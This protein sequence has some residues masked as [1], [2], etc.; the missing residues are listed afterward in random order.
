[1]EKEILQ[2]LKKAIMS[3]DPEAAASLAKEVVER[4]IDPLK[5]L[6][7]MTEA[8]REIGDGYAKGDLYLPDLIG[9]ADAMQSA[10]PII[11]KE[12]ERCGKKKETLG[13]VVIGTVAGDI[14]SIGK[15]MVATL[16][17]AQGFTVHDLGVDVKAEAFI[18]TVKKH[19]A[20]ILAMSTLLTTTAPEQGRVIDMLKEK[21]LREKVMVMVGGAAMSQEF[22]DTIGADGYD[23]TA[24]GGVKLARRLLGK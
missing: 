2:N 10:T 14:H 22:A 6:D 5:A 18:D 17:Q 23:P 4:K 7:S 3:Y 1:M 19:N 12:I 20:E 11:E 21:G 9:A 8:L 24:P 15:T 16:L 13:T